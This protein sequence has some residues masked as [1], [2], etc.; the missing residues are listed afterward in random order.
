MFK[1]GNKLYSILQMKCPRCHNANL[2]TNPNPY[3]LKDMDKIPDS[4]PNCGQD[5]QIETGFYWGAMYVSYGVTV[6]FLFTLMGLD[7][8]LTGYLQRYR[9]YLYAGLTILIW[10]LIFRL[11][12][13]IWI[14]VF[15]HYDPA[16]KKPER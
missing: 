11:S 15:V 13:S 7:I 12:R 1:K 5:F 8:L 14:N 16:T 4:C 9:L 6:G 2:F 10:P 3:N